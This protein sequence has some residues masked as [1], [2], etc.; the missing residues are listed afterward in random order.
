MGLWEGRGGERLEEGV[1]FGIWQFL[2]VCYVPYVDRYPISFLVDTIVQHS[3]SLGRTET[4]LQVHR[5]AL[6][7][8]CFTK[9]HPQISPD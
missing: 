4:R 8:A 9:Y 2:V 3:S 1:V 6:E 5:R 7:A